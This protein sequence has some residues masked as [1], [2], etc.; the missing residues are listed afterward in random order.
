MTNGAVDLVPAPDATVVV[1]TL[2]RVRQRQRTRFVAE[3][4]TPPVRRPARIAVM[5]AL[6]HKI[7]D[8]IDR[9]GASDQAEIARRLGFTPARITHL[10]DLTLLAPAIQELLLVLEAVDGVE[11]TTERALRQLTRTQSWHD[12]WARWSEL[13][14]PPVHPKIDS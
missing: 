11:P 3:L 6:A 14:M 10:L 5:L 8:A 12:Q 7:R 4:P 9:G 13:A 1:G 2:R